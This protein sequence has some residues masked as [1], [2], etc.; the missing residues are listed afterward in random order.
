MNLIS[1]IPGVGPTAAF[2]PGPSTPAPW[3]VPHTGATDGTGPASATKNMAEIYNRLLL[4]MA[5]TIQV[6]GLAID[7]NNWAQL[8]EAVS[9]IADDAAAAA[10]T[11]DAT[12]VVKGKV[13]LAVAAN[14]PSADDADEA[15]TPM[16][17]AAAIA[18]AKGYLYVREEKA[19]SVDAGGSVVGPQTRA[20]NVVVVNSLPGVTVNVGTG[21]VTFTS[22]AANGK[23]RIRA[24]APVFNV[25]G[26]RTV[27][28]DVVAGVAINVGS[29]NN[30]LT[31]Q[32]SDSTVVGEFIIAATKVTDLRSY[33]ATATA[34]NG[35]GQ[36]ANLGGFNEIYS[37]LEIF[38]VS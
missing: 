5:A 19:V 8:A 10:A 13:A 2:N 33:C 6:S 3:N 7:N 1:H 22:P 38:K 11:P 23:Y 37:E 21:Q 17:V 20:L 28:Y 4:Q 12:D 9:K 30:G 36:A 15:T 35:L 14:F 16:Y 34:G 32:N 24:R 27:F 31:G 25:D 29:S 18:A 26:N